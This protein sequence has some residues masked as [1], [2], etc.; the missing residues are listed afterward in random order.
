MQYYKFVLFCPEWMVMKDASTVKSLLL[1]NMH[2][3]KN[4]GFYD[5][6]AQDAKRAY[7]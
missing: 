6:E 5:T 7:S 3:N 1:R 2:H 4:L